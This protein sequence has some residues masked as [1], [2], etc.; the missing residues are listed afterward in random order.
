MNSTVTKV[1]S[2][3]PKL[4]EKREWRDTFIGLA[5]IAP[6]F[7]L[8]T[9][10]TL[11]PIVQGFWISLHNWEVIGTNIRFIGFANYDRIMQ[12]RLFWDSLQNTIQFVGLAGPSLIAVGLALALLLNRPYKGMGIFR[13]AFYMPNVLSVS[14]IG[15][16]FQGVFSSRTNGFANAILSTFGIE[17]IKFLTDPSIAMPMVALTT[18]WWT[19]GFNMLIFLAGLQDIPRALYDAAKVDGA[20]DFQQFFYITLPGLRRPLIFV[21][22]L[23]VIGSFQVFGQIDVLTQGGPAGSTRT[24]LYYMFQ[25]AFESWQLGYG[26]A[27]AFMLFGLLFTL[28]LAQIKLFSNEEDAI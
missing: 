2:R 17:P 28:S 10:F 3:S 27:I 7:I 18:L 8:Y 6:F 11:W 5:F 19:V 13:T 15:I 14:V 22:V 9:I 16:V 4:L 24:L 21:S 1:G 26:S 23:Q 12:D 20:S 25:R